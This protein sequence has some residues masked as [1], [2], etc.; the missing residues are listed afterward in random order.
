M[1]VRAC[2]DSACSTANPTTSAPT[3]MPTSLFPTTFPPT[4]AI[5]AY[6]PPPAPQDGSVGSTLLLIFIIVCIALFLTYNIV[7]YVMVTYCQ[8]DIAQRM[9]MSKR[10]RGSFIAV[11]P[12]QEHISN[13]QSRQHRT[14]IVAKIPVDLTSSYHDDDLSSES[15]S[16]LPEKVVTRRT[17]NRVA[18]VTSQEQLKG[19]D[20]PENR[21]KRLGMQ[22]QPD[23]D[24]V[25]PIKITDSD[26]N[27]NRLNVLRPLTVP[28][29]SNR[30]GM[31]ALDE[32]ESN[33]GDEASAGKV[34]MPMTPTQDGNMVKFMVSYSRSPMAAKD[35]N[36]ADPEWPSNGKEP[37]YNDFQLATEDVVATHERNISRQPTED[38][39]KL[40]K[41]NRNESDL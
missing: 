9:N 23:T 41:F 15:D 33:E 16:N 10:K 30:M 19:E 28:D 6:P 32:K 12:L 21:L 35:G 17:H 4:R 24:G 27:E 8:V 3:S 7:L 14:S 29:R 26:P 31:I 40:P 1:Q 38:T 13:S 2:Y 5:P 18:S 11:A 34:I 20:K 25:I 37:D 39:R 22:S 36:Q